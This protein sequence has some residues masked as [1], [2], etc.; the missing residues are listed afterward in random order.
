MWPPRISVTTRSRGQKVV[1]SV[2]LNC[3]W[4]SLRP[5][6]KGTINRRL[7]YGHVKSINIIHGKNQIVDELLKGGYF[8]KFGNLSF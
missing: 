7:R 2:A 3:N 6:L 5:V 4:P 8:K 1:V